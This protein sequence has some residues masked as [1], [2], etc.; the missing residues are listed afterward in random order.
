MYIIIYTSIVRG[1]TKVAESQKAP[2]DAKAPAPFPKAQHLTRSQEG[3][4]ARPKCSGEQ[5]RSHQV[6]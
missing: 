6:P 4:A 5:P 2:P 3:W 1:L